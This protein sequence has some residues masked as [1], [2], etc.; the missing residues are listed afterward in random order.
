[1]LFSIKIKVICNPYNTFN[2]VSCLPLVDLSPSFV[3]SDD[4]LRKPRRKPQLPPKYSGSPR[5]THRPV[6][7]IVIKNV[8]VA[9]YMD[10]PDL[11][12]RWGTGDLRVF[13]TRFLKLC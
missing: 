3:L 9:K 2:R 5:K 7:I 13:F 11:I 8:T 4:M 6:S 10:Y 12:K 1:M